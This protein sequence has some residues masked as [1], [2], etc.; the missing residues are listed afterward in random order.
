[1][2][3][4]GKYWSRYAQNMCTEHYAIHC[5]Q[6]VKMEVGPLTVACSNLLAAFW[7]PV[8]AILC[9]PGLEDFVL[10][11]AILPPGDTVLP[12]NSVK[13]VTQP[14]WVLHASESTDI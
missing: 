10:E 12:L 5:P 9:H 6:G 2:A 4:F 13:T 8:F 3:R 1:M 11:E 14:L 7:L